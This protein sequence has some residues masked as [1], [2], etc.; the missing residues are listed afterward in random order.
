MS[1]KYVTDAEKRKRIE[2]LKKKI[3]KVK[4]E[5]DYAK[6]MQLALKL[7]LNGTYG[8]LCHKAFSVSNSDIANA[9]T[10]MSREVINYM[11]DKIENFFYEEWHNEEELLNS[12]RTAYVSEFE[13]G[14]Y[15]HKYN[16]ELIDNF[17]RFEKD[18]MS[19]L[20]R[21]LYDYHIDDTDLYETDKEY[22][23][24]D[25]KK[26]NIKHKISIF[27]FTD[28]NPIPDKY[29]VEPDP[30]SKSFDK[31]R[32]VREVPVI[33]YGDTDSVTSC[34]SI[35]YENG[36]CSIEELYNR[37]IKNGCAGITLNGH[38]SV[39]CDEKVLNWCEERGLYYAPVKR[40]IRHKVT[41]PKWKLKT[42]TGKEIIITN[43]HS[44]IVFRDG[45]KIEVKPSEILKTD[46]ILV[47]LDE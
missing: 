16:G 9:I 10:A 26:Y 11:L 3:A 28:I 47:V 40:L 35:S 46:K 38:E 22:F 34:T 13:N 20:D 44:M 42:K 30:K 27:D 45:E 1:K 39:K 17:P 43:D 23:E 6:A 29:E 7:V 5:H 32:G 4:A 18:G 19:G 14:Y 25:N 36:K 2:E 21:L 41:K 31:T 33:I 24:I 37:N 8:A 12:I 15:F